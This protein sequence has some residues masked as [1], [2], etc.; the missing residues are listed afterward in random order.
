M[1][2]QDPRIAFFDRQAATWDSEEPP[3]SQTLT[4][5]QELRPMLGLQP[6]QDVLEVGC[7][8]GRVTAWLVGCVRPGHVT[9]I[10]FSPAMLARARARGLEADFRCVDVCRD[11]L[12]SGQYDVVF[13]KDAFPHFRDQTAALRRL[14]GV[15]KP[16]GRLVVLHL[17]SWRNINA[18][19][20]HVGP[21]VAGDHLPDPETW[22]KLLRDA[23]LQIGELIDRNDLFCL[24]V[25]RAV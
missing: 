22:R 6:G 16:A 17:D 21:P 19:H 20:D 10:D 7:G 12:G 9:A 11:D 23:D 24:T 13:C 3:I 14:G 4:R 8:T 15:L 25:E 1:T 5:L 18:F 2:E